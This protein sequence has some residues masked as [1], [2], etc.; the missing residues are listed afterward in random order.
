MSK[1]QITTRANETILPEFINICK[2]S[3]SEL[4]IFL[5]RKLI[6]LGYE[7]VISKDGFLYASGDVPILLT[8]HLDTVHKDKIKNYLEKIENDKHV[9]TSLQGIGG[10]DRCGVYSILQ[11]IKNKKCTVLFCEDEE[12]GG[13]G[14]TKFINSKYIEELYNLK[15][16]IE[17]DRANANDAVFYR[18]DNKKFTKF[19]CDNTGY[20]ERTGSFSDISILAPAAGIAAVN[21]SCG[22]YQAHTYAERVVIE[23][24]LNTIDIVENLVGLECEQFKYV[25]KEY[26]FTKYYNDYYNRYKDINY[27]KYSKL[28]SHEI[29]EDEYYS[30]SRLSKRRRQTKSSTSSKY[31]HNDY[32]QIVMF[33]DYLDTDGYTEHEVKVS[34]STKDELWSKFF[35]EY[36]SVCMDQVFDYFFDYI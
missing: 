12:I 31:Y 36:S 20:K 6:E 30:C 26:D 27:N 25:K 14:S 22:Y 13:R 3:Q 18:C 35:H 15:Y 17:L 7:N 8:A 2:L 1:K 24:M 16:M 11:I 29:D 32:D 23:E 5:E 28:Y 9:L 4:K 34:G 33:V 19:I 10:D 21:L